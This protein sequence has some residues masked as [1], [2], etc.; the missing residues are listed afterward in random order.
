MSAPE[1]GDDEV[2]P[3]VAR[4]HA[5]ADSEERRVLFLARYWLGRRHYSHDGTRTGLMARGWKVAS[6]R[7]R[8]GSHSRGPEWFQS[9]GVPHF[10]VPFVGHPLG[11][12][13]VLTP[14]LCSPTR[15]VVRAFRPSLLHVHWRSTSLFA[16]AE[17]L[18]AACRSSP[19]STA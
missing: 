14:P 7:Q 9:K 18:C 16:A 13:E 11:L 1:I 2:A 12:R 5:V 6:R 8:F 4:H 17:H 3:V 15:F 19:R 10:T